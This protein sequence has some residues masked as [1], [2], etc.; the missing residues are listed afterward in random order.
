MG[1]EPTRRLHDLP[2]FQG[3]LLSHLSNSPKLGYSIAY[4][5]GIFKTFQRFLSGKRGDPQK[6]WEMALKGTSP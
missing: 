5:I 6:V 4:L 2:P 3:G 1:F